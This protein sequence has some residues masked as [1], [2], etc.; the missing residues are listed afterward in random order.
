MTDSSSIYRFP[1]V[2]KQGGD[3]G[4]PFLF[5]SSIPSQKFGISF[6]N[7]RL[8]RLGSSLSIDKPQLFRRIPSDSS[9]SSNS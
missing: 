9:S 8:P 1:K 5:S 2:L 4:S 3:G 7:H 6:L